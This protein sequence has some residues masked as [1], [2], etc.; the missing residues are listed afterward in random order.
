MNN[1]AIEANPKLFGLTS[2]QIFD[3]TIEALS[4]HKI[5]VILNNHMSDAGWCCSNDDNNG[6][7]YNDKFTE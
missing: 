6:M 5:M 1:S 4:N 2:L 3:K 7:W